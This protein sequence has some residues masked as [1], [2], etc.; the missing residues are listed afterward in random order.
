[1]SSCAQGAHL[2]RKLTFHLSFSALTSMVTVRILAHLLTK[3][4]SLAPFNNI[5]TEIMNLQ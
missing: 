2:E 3:N 5:S 4:N 1:L